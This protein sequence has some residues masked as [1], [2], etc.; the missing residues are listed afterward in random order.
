MHRDI[1]PANVMLRAG[2]PADA[3]IVDFGLSFNSS[4]PDQ[5]D[6]TRINEE[7][8]NRFLRLPE[9]STGGRSPI[10]DVC[11]S[12]GLLIYALT[13]HEPRTLID[14]EGLKPHQRAAIRGILAQSLSAG[15]YRRLQ[16]VFDRAFDVRAATRYPTAGM[17][18]SAIIHAM[19]DEDPEPGLDALLAQL[20]DRI[21][22]EDHQQA[23]EHATSLKTFASQIE[24][25]AMRFA[26]SR[27][28]QC[29]RGRGPDDFLAPI[30]YGHVNMALT[31]PHATGAKSLV[32][33]RLERSADELV[34][35]IDEDVIWR[36]MSVN[37]QLEQIVVE[38]LASHYLHGNQ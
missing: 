5:S 16:S 13:G 11:Q 28:L 18:R 4:D 3:V 26:A 6:L 15:Q 36:G 29:A 14:D 37:D 31:P 32:S 8:G 17:L 30:P 7:V 20:D 38:R 21:A 23:S 33:F 19:R 22:A 2:S 12:A 27:Q 1:K 25:L 24:T 10:A 9:H 34:V 35:K